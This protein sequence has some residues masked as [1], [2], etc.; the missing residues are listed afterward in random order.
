MAT[1]DRQAR[2]ERARLRTYQ[3]RQQVHA[4]KKRRRVR[5]NI[6]AS[7]ALV[8]VLA[9]AVGVSDATGSGVPGPPV[10]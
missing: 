10:K 5:D 7:I 2:E 6:I 1:N 8:I 4:G 9:L 3:A